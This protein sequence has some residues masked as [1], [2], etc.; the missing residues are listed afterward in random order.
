MQIP[1]SESTKELK[2]TISRIE[3]EL[4]TLKYERTNAFHQSQINRLDN[5]TKEEENVLK[6]L[7]S[8]MYYEI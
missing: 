3:N 6:E 2:R 4:I 5:I 1:E 8:L 7:K